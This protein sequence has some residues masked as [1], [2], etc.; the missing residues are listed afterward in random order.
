MADPVVFKNGFFALST[1]VAITHFGNI[2][3]V[4]LPIS[5]EELDDAVMGDNAKVMFP[6]IQS[7]EAVTVRLKQ[8]FTTG[9]VDSK[10]WTIFNGKKLCFF[11]ARAVNGAVSSSNPSYL[12]RG[13]VMNYPPI[14]GGHGVALETTISIRLASGSSITR[15]TTT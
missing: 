12:G 15:S 4:T 5:H 6:G 1:G 10:L 13:Y 14:S 8:D 2:K 7:G 9:S 3:E 11:K